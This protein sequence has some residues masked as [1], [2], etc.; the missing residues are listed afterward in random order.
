MPN[1]EDWPLFHPPTAVPE[2]VF[3]SNE[4]TLAGTADWA[5]GIGGGAALRG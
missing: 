5:T 1:L 3:G 2:D 4:G